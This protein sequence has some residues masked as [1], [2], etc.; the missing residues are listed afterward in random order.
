M[1]K[2][3]TKKFTHLIDMKVPQSFLIKSLCLPFLLL[4][5][6]YLQAQAP[7]TPER[8]KDVKA[9][10][11]TSW[12]QLSVG[13]KMFVNSQIF[14][15]AGQ[16]LDLAK[17]TRILN[18]ELA[19]QNKLLV[20]KSNKG[21]AVINADNFKVVNQFEY[22]KGESGS[23]YGLAVSNDDS[24]VY[25][26]GAQRNL[27][28]GNLSK[29]GAFKLTKKIDLSVDKKTTTPLGIGLVDD[30]IAFVALAIPNQVA[31]VA[32]DK[33]KVLSKIPVGVCPYAIVISNDK[34]YAFVSNFG[35]PNPKKGD[36]TEESDGTKVA[37]DDRSIA[38][39]GS[40][41]VI[42]IQ[43]RKVIHEIST[44]IYPES[45]VLSPDGNLL[46]VSDDSGDGI[47]VI[48]AKKFKVVQTINTKPDPS[49]PYGSLTTGLAFSPNGKVLYAANAGNNSIAL[50]NPQQPQ[51][52]PYGFIAGGG[53][54]GAVCVTT[55]DLF[56]GNVT[57]LK[58]GSL[59]K[60]ALPSNKT[61]LDNYTAKA[62]K[63]FHFIEMLRK[64]AEV[65]LNAKPKPVPVNVGEPSAIK[66]VVY[67]IR[68]NKKFDQE[69]GDFGKGNCDSALV[70][71]AKQVTPN[72]HSLAEQFVLLDNYYCNG[73]NSSDGH[74]WAT[75]G[76]SSPY[77]EKDFSGGR[78]A[79]DFG[80][81]PLCY[82]GCDFIWNHLLRKGISFK[83]FGEFDLADVTKDKTWTDLYN[84][85]KDQS[86]SIWYKCGYQIK[87]LEKYSDLRFPG[88][89]L[90][91]PDQI[92]A[93]VFVKALKEYEAKGSFPDFTIIYLPNDH[94]SGYG[95]NLPTPRAYVAD[96]DQA[97]GRVIEA[98]SKSPFWKDM[99]IFVNED[100]PQSGTDH[101]DGH[102]SVCFVAGP[103]VK[104]HTIISKFYNQASVLHT[105][106]QI[107]GVEPMNQ[108]VAIAPLM[109]EC[110]KENP[111]YTG[112]T[113]L[114][115]A[116]AINEMNPPRKKMSKTTSRL[117]PLTAKMDF[118][119][120]DLNDKDALLFSEYLWST[121]HGDQPFPKEYFGAHGKGLKA[122]GLKT[123]PLF[124]NDDD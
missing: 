36:R 69:L 109:T 118:S 51:K 92:R 45:M 85:W 14:N 19:H 1:G 123:D 52:G 115:P 47:S 46:Y 61:Q 90:N 7:E 13:D 79:Y 37:V 39:R 66:H 44:R 72:A 77:H 108:L 120:P 75:Q 48:D 42:D 54:P 107:F 6:Q 113:S 35:G 31:V 97:T 105:I 84:G 122:L 112:Y 43:S 111:D 82:A 104:R 60:V 103:Y 25:F 71:Y 102:R 83:N 49:L 26:T 121:I 110:F 81:D 28:I 58:Q 117:A 59:Q 40:V 78:C 62:E 16:S 55:R 2:R 68:E 114:T 100:D 24:T 22:E 89:N 15:P 94:T 74:Q 17:G 98:L 96:N 12:N 18:L 8:R 21:L 80:T 67:I 76:I 38:L 63:G 34:R 119:K 65:N 23:M 5:S 86:D 33:G 4:V 95:E 9:P 124:K 29:S 99:A 10:A 73:I 64:Q 50:I 70:E 53:F 101:V 88:W 32:I 57:P 20:S 30:H 56:I 27:Y 87:S 106:C 91:I 11:D 3:I 116:I 41:T 93:D